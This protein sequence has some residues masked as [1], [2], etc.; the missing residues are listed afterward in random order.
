[1]SGKIGILIDAALHNEL[2]LRTRKAADVTPLIEHAL[3]TFLDRTTADS[4]LWSD[5]YLASVE[6]V[7]VD[8]HREKYGDPNKGFR[9]QAL[10]LPNGSRLKMTY[11]GQTAYAEICHQKL[12]YEGE[13]NLSPSSWV[14]RVANNTSRNA[15]ND[16]WVQLPGSTQWQL[17]DV[18]RR[19][20]RDE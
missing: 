7:Q 6:G 16:V 10:L 2:V 4:E 13:D 18:M 15:W 9:W 20:R 3:T 19:E 17:S 12:V 14:R 5:D 8:V 1:M 11:K